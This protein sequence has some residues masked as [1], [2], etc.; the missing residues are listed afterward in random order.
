MYLKKDVGKA[1]KKDYFKDKWIENSYY[2]SKRHEYFFI[3]VILTIMTT[4]CLVVDI[5]YF[6]SKI[7]S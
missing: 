6:G 1:L 2:M 4:F 3:N 7:K 5:S